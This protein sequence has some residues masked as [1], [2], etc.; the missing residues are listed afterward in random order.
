MLRPWPNQ[1]IGLLISFGKI[2]GLIAAVHRF[3]PEP[4]NQG[5]PCLF[6]A[7]GGLFGQSGTPS[8]GFGRAD[9]WNV[10]PRVFRRSKELRLGLFQLA[11]GI[12]RTSPYGLGDLFVRTH[13]PK[14]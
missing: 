2:S 6:D 13:T 8:A 11:H 1:K 3:V 5:S 12:R 14:K 9:E 4:A 10:F 7:G